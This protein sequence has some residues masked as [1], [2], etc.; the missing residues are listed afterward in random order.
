MQNLSKSQNKV[1][2]NDEGTTVSVCVCVFSTHTVCIFFLT[3]GVF[4]TVLRSSEEFTGKR[5]KKRNYKH[6]VMKIR[7]HHCALVVGSTVWLLLHTFGAF[8][9]ITSLPKRFPPIETTS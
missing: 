7:R 5:M 6:S 4:L 9:D 8:A 1:V 2:I 3:G